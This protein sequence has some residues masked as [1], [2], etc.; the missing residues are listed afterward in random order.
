MY[1]PSSPIL[2]KNKERRCICG[3]AKTSANI[4]DLIIAEQKTGSIG[5]KPFSGL[6]VAMD[7]TFVPPST[8]AH[9][10]AERC[11]GLGR[12]GRKSAP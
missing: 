4:R 1:V 2:Y 12:C 8:L 6:D 10:G 3:G 7:S 9:N 5:F 11:A